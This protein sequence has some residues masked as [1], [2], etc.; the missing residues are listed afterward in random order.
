[1]ISLISPIVL[2]LAATNKFFPSLVVMLDIS[3]KNLYSLPLEFIFNS[4]TLPFTFLEVVEYL[5][6][7]HSDFIYDNFSGFLSKKKVKVVVPIPDIVK[8]FLYS[9]S[10]L[11]IF[12]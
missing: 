7:S 10:F 11:I 5:R 12:E 1:M 2:E 6:T 8:V 3:G 4:L 9:L